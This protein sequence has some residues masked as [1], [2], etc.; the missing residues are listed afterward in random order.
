MIGI[1]EK[2]YATLRVTANAP[3]GHSS[4][5]PAETGVTVLAKAVLAIAD[6]P[7]PLELRGPGLAMSEALEAETGGT[8]KMT[9]ANRWLFAPPRKRQ[10]ANSP[11]TPGAFHPTVA[12]PQSAQRHN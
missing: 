6:D 8:T 9:V 3:G 10:L 1:G 11:S 4:M 5:P 12:P 2:G 7:F